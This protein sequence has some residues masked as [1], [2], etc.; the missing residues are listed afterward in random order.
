MVPTDPKFIQGQ[1]NGFLVWRLSC[2]VSLMFVNMVDFSTF[3]LFLI[4]LD[5]NINI[6]RQ[7]INTFSTLLSN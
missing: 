2:M 6:R 1:S 4:W 7:K 5:G 3:M